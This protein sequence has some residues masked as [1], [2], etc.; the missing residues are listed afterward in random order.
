MTGQP[1]RED[2]G[3]TQRL[4]LFVAI[5]L[6]ESWLASLQKLMDE[7]KTAFARDLVTR[8]ARLR[9]VR[10]E[11]IHLTLKF[12]GEV[13]QERLTDIESALAAAVSTAPNINIELGAT[14]TFGRSP[15]VLWVGLSGDMRAL[16][17]LA[18]RVDAACASAGFEREKR[19]LA[20]HL[21][22]ARLPDDL[23]QAP[24]SGIAEIAIGRSPPRAPSFKVHHVS[25]MRSH[26]GPGGARYEHLARFPPSSSPG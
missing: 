23:A 17:D 13:Q 5:E 21:T 24:R 2:E 20:P 6:P 19:P 10:P 14:G 12:L 25:L 26:L 11:G 18:V 4:R 7:L 3:R 8:E 1:R 22:L 15:R 9:W 16:S